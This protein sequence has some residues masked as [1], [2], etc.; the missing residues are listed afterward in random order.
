MR[1]VPV[2]RADAAHG[3]AEP[4]GFLVKVLLPDI[5]GAL[6]L[7]RVDHVLDLVASARCLDEREPIFTRKVSGLRQDLDDIAV[8]KRTLQRNDAAIDLRA[9]ARMP[10]IGVNR[11]RE[12]DRSSAPR[13]HDD[14]A[15]AE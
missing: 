10:D 3:D 8:L 2:R 5:D 7:R 4:P 11:V 14:P 13:Q 9:D 1:H 6:P 12:I 15:R